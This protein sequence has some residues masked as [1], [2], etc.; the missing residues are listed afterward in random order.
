MKMHPISAILVFAFTP[1]GFQVVNFFDFVVILLSLA[2]YGRCTRDDYFCRHASIVF[3]C[4][5]VIVAISVTVNVHTK[6]GNYTAFLFI[7]KA[8]IVGTVFTTSGF[9]S[10][11]HS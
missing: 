2:Y 10:I 7:N 9:A 6:E 4:K 5:S 8:A 1:V 3:V 11:P